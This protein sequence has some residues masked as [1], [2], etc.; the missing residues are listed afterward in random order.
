MA[1]ICN[2]LLFRGLD[3]YSALYDK[4]A[5]IGDFNAEGSEDTLAYFFNCHNSSNIVRDKACFKSLSNPSCV[6]LIIINNFG[7]F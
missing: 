3:I 4:I 5:L 7:C 6:E 2:I 1:F